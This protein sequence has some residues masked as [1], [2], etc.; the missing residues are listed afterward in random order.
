M[1]QTARIEYLQYPIW[2]WF[3]ERTINEKGFIAYKHKHIRQEPE[4]DFPL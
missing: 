1:L 2:D 4:Q 3:K